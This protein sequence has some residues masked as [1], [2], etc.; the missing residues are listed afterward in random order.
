M[1]HIPKLIVS[2]ISGF[3]QSADR[4]NGTMQAVLAT[5]EDNHGEC[6]RVN[7]HTW[8]DDLDG[9]AEFHHRAFPG[10]P[11]I[12][13]GYSLG[14]EAAANL[15][16][17]L[18]DLGESV[19][20]VVVVDGVVDGWWRPWR[21]LLGK[22]KVRP[23]VKHVYSYIQRKNKP[24]GDPVFIGNRPVSQI[25]VMHVNHNDIDEHYLP[26]ERLKTAIQ[27]QLKGTQ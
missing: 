25:E 15:A 8:D 19:D 3:T 11:H 27:N 26:Q 18:V 12:I 4:M 23:E 6:V 22:I 1:S 10:V 20:A 16:N 13:W 14:G 21:W 7:Y 24:D 5:I 17:K 9:A 2:C